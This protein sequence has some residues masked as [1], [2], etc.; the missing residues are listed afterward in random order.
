MMVKRLRWVVIV[1][2]TLGLALV[3]SACGNASAGPSTTIKPSA[4][5][6]STG[7]SPGVTSNA[8]T[9]GTLATVTGDLAPGFGEITDGTQAYFDLINSE[10]GVNGRKIYIKYQENDGGSTTNDETEAR[11]LV[12]QDHVFAVVAVGTPFFTGSTFL[13]QSGTPTFGYV[14][15]Q[16]WNQY[17]NLF[18]AYGSYLDYNTEEPTAGFIASAVHAKSVAVLAY[19]FGPSSA[20][21]ADIGK[22]ITH[23]GFHLGFEDLNFS[24]DE[25]P[26]ADVQKMKNAGVD[27]VYSCMEGTDNLAFSK[28]MHQFGMTTHF[29]WLNGYSQAVIKANTGVMNGVLFGEQHVPFEAGTQFPGVYPGLQLY[30]NTMQKYFPQYLDDDTAMQGWIC[31]EQF[32]AGLKAIGRNVTQ[33]RLVDVIN[34]E[35]DYNAGGLEPPLNWLTGHTSAIPPYCGAYVEDE[36]GKT[37]VVFGK[38]SSVF[39]CLGANSDQRIPNPPN[40]P[41]G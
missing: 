16:D 26:D 20:P 41:G 28:A 14:V 38:G 1:A 30:F 24:I 27:L 40:T 29:V 11:T 22:G 6:P 12:E 23:Y 8:I 3:L 7:K 21:C 15:T 10:G 2:G 9:V 32:V 17:P 36:N 4:P 35:T 19:N 31:A 18:G 33:N 37:S 25:N 34:R 39:V 5:L 13:A